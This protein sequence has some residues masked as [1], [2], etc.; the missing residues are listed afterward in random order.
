MRIDAHA[1]ACGELNNI[2]GILRY[3]SKNKLE[4]IVLCPGEHNSKKNYPL[5][6]VAD[7]FPTQAVGYGLNRMIRFV[8][9]VTKAAEFIDVQNQSIAALSKNYPQII[10]QAY[11]INPDEDTAMDKMVSMYAES[12]FCMIKL[13]QCWN[14]FEMKSE[15]MRTI[16]KW[17]AGANRPIFIHLANAKQCTDF[18]SIANT[19][20][21]VTFIVGHMIG[22]PQM[23]PDLVSDNVY[24]DISAPFMI[25]MDYL[26]QAAA[27]G[28]ANKLILGSD[29]PYGNHNIQKNMERIEKMNISAADKEGI[30]GGNFTKLISS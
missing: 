7:I 6:M 21:D 5:P 28:M 20:K 1:H 27:A 18:V 9:K 29:T 23:L 15:N 17:A 19:Y 2:E 30:L 16:I 14:N 25:P 10:L 4:K 8:T 12:P 22:F 26:T 24:F 13:H 11:W 3:L